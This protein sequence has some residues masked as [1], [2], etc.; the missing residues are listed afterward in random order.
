MVLGKKAVISA[1]GTQ[2]KKKKRKKSKKAGKRRVKALQLLPPEI[3]AA[4]A[5]GGIDS[6]S[7]DEE[8]KERR[9]KRKRELHASKGHLL[10]LLPATKSRQA[11]DLLL[12]ANRKNQEAAARQKAD[13]AAAAAKEDEESDESDNEEGMDLVANMRAKME[14]QAKSATAPKPLFTFAKRQGLSAAPP[15]SIPGV[16]AAT[17]AVEEQTLVEEPDRPSEGSAYQ[18]EQE[19]QQQQVPVYSQQAAYQEQQEIMGEGAKAGR[20]KQR[21]LERMLASGQ[22]DALNQGYGQVSKSSQ[23]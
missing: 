19:P 7:E 9:K 20:R 18:L 23:V 11:A 12:E 17:A 1:E 8:E 14:E 2:E 13:A 16:A 15:V 10:D 5:Q 6:D 4:L 3:Q 21:D 22:L